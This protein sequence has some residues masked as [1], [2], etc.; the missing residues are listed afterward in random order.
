MIK[1]L[2]F[3]FRVTIMITFGVVVLWFLMIVSL[4]LWD[5][6]YLD[7]AENFS[8]MIKKDLLK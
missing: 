8:D 3:L 4:L 6:R 2:T 5:I 1:L 7:M